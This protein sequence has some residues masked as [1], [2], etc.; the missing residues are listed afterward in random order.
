MMFVT[1]ERNNQFKERAYSSNRTYNPGANPPVY[2]AWVPISRMSLVDSNGNPIA[3]NNISGPYLRNIY[4]AECFQ[5]NFLYGQ[6]NI[7]PWS[8]TL[9][10][11]RTL[12]YGASLGGIMF[13][14]NFQLK[15]I[16]GLVEGLQ[17]NES[18]RVYVRML[19]YA[20]LTR[21]PEGTFELR[22]L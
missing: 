20:T 3:Y 4:A 18:F 12:Q 9:Q 8:W 11:K 15:I 13:D 5:G 22:K 6:K 1:L 21:T 10:A 17:P 19:R 2:H 7:Y 16:P 14:S